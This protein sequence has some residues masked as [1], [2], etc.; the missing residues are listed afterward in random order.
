MNGGTGGGLVELFGG[1]ADA[2]LPLLGGEG[3]ALVLLKG[4]AV[5]LEVDKELANQLGDPGPEVINCCAV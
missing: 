4:P 2:P 3:L 1:E 5:W